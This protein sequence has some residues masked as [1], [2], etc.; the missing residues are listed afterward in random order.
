MEVPTEAFAAQSF[1][2]ATTINQ[3]IDKIVAMMEHTADV[4]PQVAPAA[5]EETATMEAEVVK[6]AADVK[7]NLETNT[8]SQDETTA[9]DETA[10]MEAVVMK[11]TADAKPSLGTSTSAQDE[12]AAKY[13]EEVLDT[14]E[15]IQ[16]RF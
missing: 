10:T 3:E 4:K 1:R 6:V 13:T 11:D 8:S 2:E 16:E 14:A 12:T 9:K 15:L 5:H 7:P